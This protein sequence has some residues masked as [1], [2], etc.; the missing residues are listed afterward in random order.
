[1]DNTAYDHMGRPLQQLTGY[2]PV[3]GP[4]MNHSPYMHVN[5]GNHVMN[6]HPMNPA[7]DIAMK[8]DKDAIY[9]YVIE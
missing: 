8:R 3:T 1:M 5:Q 2:N 4:P 6:S 9:G 7:H